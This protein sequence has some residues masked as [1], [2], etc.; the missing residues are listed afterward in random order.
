MKCIICRDLARAYEAGRSEYI[1]ALSSACS[2]VCTNLMAEKNVDMERAK[3]ELEEH[4]LVCASAI[5]ALAPLPKLDVFT[6][7]RQL[8]AK[9]RTG[10]PRQNSKLA[11]A[12][13]E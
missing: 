2:E 10:Y 12:T 11:P 4:R 6:L 5:R 8:A 3:Y 1:K 9:Y 13:R 7:L